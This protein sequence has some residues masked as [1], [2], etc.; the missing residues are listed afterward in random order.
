MNAGASIQ[1]LEWDSTIAAGLHPQGGQGLIEERADIQNCDI[2]VGIIRH[3]LGRVVPATDQTY[4]QKEIRTARDAWKAR[5]KPNVM[6]YFAAPLSSPTNADEARSAELIAEFKDELRRDGL[7]KDYQNADR[8][9]ARLSIELPQA[10]LDALGAV[11]LSNVDVVPVYS[12][13]VRSCGVSEYTKDVEVELSGFRLS[14]TGVLKDS[15]LVLSFN[16]NVTGRFGYDKV[17]LDALCRLNET[18]NRGE[19][20][21]YVRGVQASLNYVT[22]NG[23]PLVRDPRSTVRVSISGLRLNANQLGVSS[24]ASPTTAQGLLVFRYRGTDGSE[25]VASVAF[26]LA[27]IEQSL[28][29]PHPLDTL[30]QAGWDG[31]I[32]LITHRSEGQRK[33]SLPDDLDLWLLPMGLKIQP[34][35]QL[36]SMAEEEPSWINHWPQ[37]SSK[38]PC[39]SDEG[40]WNASQIVLRCGGFPRGTRLFFPIGLWDGAM[41]RRHTLL[42]RLRVGPPHLSN[43]ST[44][45]LDSDSW[46][47]DVDGSP[48]CP[49]FEAVDMFGS[50]CA[51]WEVQRCP[52]VDSADLVLECP[53]IVAAPPDVDWDEVLFST[54]LGP[55]TTVLTASCTQPCPR[56]VDNPVF[57]KGATG[58]SMRRLDRQRVVL[59][60]GGPVGG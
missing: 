51:I 19:E 59:R 49:C 8:L 7:T 17:L 47:F 36:S 33:S 37:K 10:I 1:V 34:A 23:L 48:L 16:T 42:A 31:G 40:W 6:A 54:N 26:T 5:G 2:V 11:R 13:I 15:Q 18:P 57:L 35:S 32:V 55:T 56:F 58:L 22:F 24:T 25:R 53:I 50:C 39:A 12:R 27:V 28:I 9:E 29:A 4:T 3:G 52:Q 60:C 38:F 41:E 43:E 21:R 45:P 44:L 20:A 30:S 46:F 14:S